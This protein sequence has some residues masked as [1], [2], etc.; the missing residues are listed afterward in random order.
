MIVVRCVFC[1]LRQWAIRS[2]CVRCR[3]N[4]GFFVV[5]VPLRSNNA[6]PNGVIRTNPQI[7]QVIRSL[8]LRRGKSQLQ[9]AEI[10]HISRSNLCRIE[11]S[12]A[13]PNVHTLLTVLRAVGVESLYLMANR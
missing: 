7:G 9:I 10:A 8:R 12:V 4:L 6:S 13:T 5:E 2:T 1:G 3:A 11:K